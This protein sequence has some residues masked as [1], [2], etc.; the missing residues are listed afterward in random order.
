MRK[1]ESLVSRCDPKTFTAGD[2]MQSSVVTCNPGDT[3]ETVALL[4]CDKHF[5]SIPV[6][7]HAQ[8]LVG[9]VSEFDL[10]RVMMVEQD[11]RNVAVGTI[12][13]R[14]VITVTE[15]IPVSDLIKCFQD[16]QLIRVP[17]VKGRTVVGIV[18]RRDVLFG[19]VKAV[20]YYL[21]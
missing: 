14:I 15:D 1:V 13:T 5:G 6:V 21:G 16:N 17:V 18:A 11:L 2:L 7:D 20:T 19:Y 9:L 8:Q 3:A 4:L 10:L 12:M